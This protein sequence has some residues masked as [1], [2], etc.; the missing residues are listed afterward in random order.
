M[1]SDKFIVCREEGQVAMIDLRAGAQVTRRPIGADAAIMNPEH[2]ILALRSNTTVQI[3]NLD[4]KQKLKSHN[5]PEPLVF[6]KWTSPSNLAMVTGTAVYHWPLEGNGPP[7]KL[8]DRQS[9]AAPMCK[10]STTASLPTE[11]GAC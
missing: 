11:S 3:F 10:S 1:E 2:S 9:N 8:F 6:W 4:S 7:M 5:M